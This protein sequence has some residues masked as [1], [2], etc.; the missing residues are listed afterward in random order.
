VTRKTSSL[1]RPSA[2][3][4]SAAPPERPKLVFA[5]DDATGAAKQTETPARILVVEDDFLVATDVEAALLDAGFDVVGVAETAEH[6][7]ELAAAENPALILMDIRLA[8]RRDGIDTAIQIYREHGIRCLFASA[9]SDGLAR[10]RAEP[11]KPLGWLQKPY[12][13]DRLV[14]AVKQALA[15]ASDV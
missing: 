4:R 6:A 14:A 10:N 1:P 2:G 12:T 5:R 15:A 3:D 11:A 9:H 7:I 13:M 8:G